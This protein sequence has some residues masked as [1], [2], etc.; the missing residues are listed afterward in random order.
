MQV[1]ILDF[2]GRLSDDVTYPELSNPGA[3][4]AEPEMAH[5]DGKLDME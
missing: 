2:L 4:P 3:V 1:C 5:M